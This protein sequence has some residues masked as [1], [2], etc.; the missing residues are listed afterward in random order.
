MGYNSDDMYDGRG[1]LSLARSAKRTDVSG[2]QKKL[3]AQRLESCLQ[4]NTH[5]NETAYDMLIL[6]KGVNE[7]EKLQF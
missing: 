5:C 6:W 7:I 3:S 1:D 2:K 4:K